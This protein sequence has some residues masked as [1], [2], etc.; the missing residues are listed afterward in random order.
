MDPEL[1]S[2]ED[3]PH[4]VIGTSARRQEDDT[5]VFTLTGSSWRVQPAEIERWTQ[6]YREDSKL[7]VAYEELSQ[8][9]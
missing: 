5:G 4:T 1:T 2:S 7:S 9:K 6:A 3:Q 8:G